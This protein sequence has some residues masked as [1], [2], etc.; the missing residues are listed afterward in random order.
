MWE[1]GGE[2]WE[3]GKQGGVYCLKV[4]QSIAGKYSRLST[5]PLAMRDG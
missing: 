3:S 5:L 2:E 4:Y 1:E